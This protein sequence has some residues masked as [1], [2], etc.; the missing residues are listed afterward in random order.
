LGAGRL[1]VDKVVE[2][3]K[4]TGQETTIELDQVGVVRA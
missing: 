1:G 4:A 3:V 2:V